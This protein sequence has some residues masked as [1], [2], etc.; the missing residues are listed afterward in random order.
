MVIESFLRL[1]YQPLYARFMDEQADYS[2]QGVIRSSIAT[3]LLT[4][5]PELI[6]REVLRRKESVNRTQARC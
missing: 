2:R 4:K 1:L 3:H 5:D 6:S